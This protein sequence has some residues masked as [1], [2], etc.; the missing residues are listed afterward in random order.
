LDQDV[1]SSWR[2]DEARV[3]AME[4]LW[5]RVSVIEVVPSMISASVIVLVVFGGLSRAE[6]V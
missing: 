1:D 5:M 2:R 4:Y 6:T 3:A